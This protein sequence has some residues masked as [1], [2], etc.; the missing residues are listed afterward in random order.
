[1]QPVFIVLLRFSTHRAAAREHRDAHD[2]W[3]RQGFEDGV[4]LLAGSLDRAE[5]G[6]VLAAGCTA[7][8]LADRVGQ[9]PFVRHRVVEAEIRAVAP[10]RVAPPL[11]MLA[12]VDG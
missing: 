10:G 11:A 6:I 9:D 5:G 12:G 4:F 2:A 8:A 7:Q 1:M 3:I